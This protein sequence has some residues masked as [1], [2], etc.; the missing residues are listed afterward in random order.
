MNVTQ[1]GPSSLYEAYLASESDAKS[2]PALAYVFGNKFT[3]KSTI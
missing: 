1:N 2:V 3:V